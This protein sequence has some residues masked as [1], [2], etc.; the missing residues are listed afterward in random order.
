MLNSECMNLMK[1]V[2]ESQTRFK[3]VANLGKKQKQMR[4][5]LNYTHTN[6]YHHVY[7]EQL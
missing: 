5:I 4:F 3:K 2:K 7:I 6:S 1:A